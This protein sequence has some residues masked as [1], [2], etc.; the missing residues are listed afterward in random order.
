MYIFVLSNTLEQQYP[1]ICGF[2]KQIQLF[3]SICS[4]IDS[5]CFINSNGSMKNV[6]HIIHLFESREELAVLIDNI[7]STQSQVPASLKS[8]QYVIVSVR[9]MTDHINNCRSNNNN[10]RSNN[11]NNSQYSLSF[12]NKVLTLF[13]GFIMCPSGIDN[14]LKNQLKYLIVK[15]GGTYSGI[16]SSSNTTHLIENTFNPQSISAKHRAMV[17]LNHQL[18]N[19]NNKERKVHIIDPNF[20][21]DCYIHGCKLNEQ[22][23]PLKIFQ[24]TYLSV[25]G[26]KPKSRT[27]IRKTVAKLGGKVEFYQ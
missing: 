15:M 18:E 11:N 26:L 27:I 23:Y 14:T 13:K 19:M 9:M 16:F 22:D 17:T 6:T 5:S 25:T 7:D 10:N 21:F 1:E 3:D 12:I 2:V 24:N 8:I 4:N 20:I